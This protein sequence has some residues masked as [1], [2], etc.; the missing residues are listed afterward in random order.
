M[1]WLL[2]EVILKI[3]SNFNDSTLVI[4]TGFYFFLGM[5]ENTVRLGGLQ[6]EQ[7]ASRQNVTLSSQ[8]KALFWN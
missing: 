5:A 3:F 7:L 6:S 4:T 8:A 1:G 2:D